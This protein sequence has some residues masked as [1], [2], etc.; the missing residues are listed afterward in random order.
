MTPS[1]EFDCGTIIKSAGSIALACKAHI[2]K[3]TNE[4]CQAEVKAEARKAGL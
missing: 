4:A 2:G 3:C 1:I